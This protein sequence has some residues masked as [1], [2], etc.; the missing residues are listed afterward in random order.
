[1]TKLILTAVVLGSLFLTG[2][3]DENARRYAKE[4]VGV[5][6]TYQTEVNKKITA[7]QRSYKDL[8]G[9]HAY[10]REVELLTRLR[11]ERLSRANSLT[12]DLIGGRTMSPSD[13]HKLLL[14]HANVEFEATRQALIQESDGQAAYIAS[15]ESLEL[16]AQNIAQLTQALEALAKPKSDLKKMRELAAAAKE[17]KTRFDELECAE[18]A[19]QIACLKAQQATIDAATDL[20]PDRKKAKKQKL[21]NQIKSLLELGKEQK[22]DLTK[23]TTGKCPD[24]KG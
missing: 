3:D 17:L 12:D 18:L 19:E 20:T 8:A 4:L 15:L 5:L 6:K 21:E 7:E 13:I 14:D 11:T 9:A 22:C 24:K 23:L 2:C 10:A 16:Q 1:M